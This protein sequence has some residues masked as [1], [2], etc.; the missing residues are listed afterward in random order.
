MGMGM[1]AK[2]EVEAEPE[3]EAEAEAEAEY[4]GMSQERSANYDANVANFIQGWNSQIELE[5]FIKTDL[6]SRS[7]LQLCGQII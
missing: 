1:K 3:G 6:I 4:M 5:V 2:A 7:I